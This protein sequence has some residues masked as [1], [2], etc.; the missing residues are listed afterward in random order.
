MDSGI[1]LQD[2]VCLPQRPEHDWRVG[3][4]FVDLQGGERGRDWI[5]SGQWLSPVCLRS[6]TSIKTSRQWSSENFQ[7]G[8]H[9]KVHPQRG[10]RS[11]IPRPP[12]PPI[13]LCLFLSCILYNKLI[14]VRKALF[15]SSVSCFSKLS[16]LRDWGCGTQEF[17][18]NWAEMRVAW[19]LHLVGI[20][21]GDRLVGLSPSLIGSTLT[22]RTGI[23]IELLDT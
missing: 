16:N 11:S 4:F 23:R 12:H 20:W 9:T 7:G 1:E 19:A 6:K 13:W 21:S 5:D 10:H 2:R 8:E 18:V 3:I 15:L 17:I 14:I 22:S